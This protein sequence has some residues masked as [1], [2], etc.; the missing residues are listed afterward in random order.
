MV[1]SCAPSLSGRAGT[2]TPVCHAPAPVFLC[3]RLRTRMIAWIICFLCLLLQP[4]GCAEGLPTL[5]RMLW[6][7]FFDV[8]GL[9][10]LGVK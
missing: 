2:G 3:C 10:V 6:S 5:L 8:C 1:Q 9:G 7:T 4:T